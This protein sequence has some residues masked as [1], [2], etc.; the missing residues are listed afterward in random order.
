MCRL[1]V[2]LRH[3]KAGYCSN[4]AAAAA[5]ICNSVIPPYIHTYMC[6]CSVQT[7][8]DYMHLV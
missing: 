8:V 1:S 4:A 5:A 7:E 2:V 3:Q 6:V